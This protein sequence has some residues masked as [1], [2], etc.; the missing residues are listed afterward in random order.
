MPQ[1]QRRPD[2]DD[3][4]DDERA[5]A[6]ERASEHLIQARRE[7]DRAQAASLR[8][9][10]NMALVEAATLLGRCGGRRGGRH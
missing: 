3:D 9:F 7:T 8:V 4:D 2:G 1:A 5:A 10:V 6:L